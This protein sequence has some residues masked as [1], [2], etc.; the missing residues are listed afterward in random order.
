MCYTGKCK[1]ED[2]WGEC[3]LGPRKPFPYDAGCIIRDNERED[4]VNCKHFGD[5]DNCAMWDFP[6]GEPCPEKEEK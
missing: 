2:Y 3:T 5:P 1:Y 4:C 6:D